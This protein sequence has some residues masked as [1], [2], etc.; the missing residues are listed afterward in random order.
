MHF[1][2]L[3][4]FPKAFMQGCLVLAF[5]KFYKSIF[6]KDCFMLEAILYFPYQMP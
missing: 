2:L 6:L 1:K 3:L 4:V 5:Q